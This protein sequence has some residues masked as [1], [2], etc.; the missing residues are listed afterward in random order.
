VNVITVRGKWVISTTGIS[1]SKNLTS[2]AVSLNSN[3]ISNWI[4][5]CV[6]GVCDC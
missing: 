5:G 4:W 1:T 3:L 2:K 6:W